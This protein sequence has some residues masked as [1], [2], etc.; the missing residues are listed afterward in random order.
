MDR[1]FKILSLDGGGIRGY[2]TL[3]NLKKIEDFI[4]EKNGET[5]ALGERFHLITGT[6]TGSIIAALL[7]EKRPVQEIIQIYEKHIPQIF[8]KKTFFPKLFTKYDSKILNK[9]A[10]ELWSNE[11]K[12]KDLSIDI[13]IPTVDLISVAAKVYRSYKNSDDTSNE[14]IADVIVAS[15][16]APTYFAPTQNLSN[17]FASID[18]GL[19][20]N[21]PTLLALLDYI[22]SPNKYK[23]YTG[24]IKNT[25]A[26]TIILSLGTGL[27]QRPSYD[28]NNLTKGSKGQIQWA[29]SVIHILMENQSKL[30]DQEVQM[31]MKSYNNSA[32]YKRI[33]PV[34]TTNIELDD[35]DKL[36][37]LLSF[38]KLEVED[39][40]FLET[41]FVERVSMNNI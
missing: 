33:N 23:N 22:S 19:V 37:E 29:K 18:G 20:A 14:K 31:L 32:S 27:N 17:T 26:N 2:L 25:V 6:S 8:Q 10:N 40:E 36:D 16:S 1:R 21:N 28:A 39:Y 24:E 3:L 15:S 13:V 5:K 11:K 34:L 7:A 35:A 4:N 9:V 38:S 12:L 30:V 41:Y